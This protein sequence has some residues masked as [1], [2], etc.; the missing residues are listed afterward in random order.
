MIS[1]QIQDLCTEIVKQRFMVFCETQRVLSLH[2]HPLTM[3]KNNLV[4]K[5]KFIC[6]IN[7]LPSYLPPFFL[8]FLSLP[9]L[10]L[11][12]ILLILIRGYVYQFLEREEGRGRER[13]RNTDVTE[14]HRLV[15]SS[16]H[17]YQGSNP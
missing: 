5:S 6:Q 1:V 4:V 7:F 12:F 15:A 13:E 16:M 9:T 8:F 2:S 3:V 11:S 17:P 14:K 10:L